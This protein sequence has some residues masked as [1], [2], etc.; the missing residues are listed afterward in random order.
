MTHCLTQNV[1]ERRTGN[2]HASA[3]EQAA[4]KHL[5]LAEKHLRLAENY[6]RAAEKHLPGR[7]QAVPLRNSVAWIRYQTLPLY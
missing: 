5:R 4:E 2:F 1:D 3:D 7:F 6:L